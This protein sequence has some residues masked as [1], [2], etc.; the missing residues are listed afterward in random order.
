M[1][2]E[3]SGHTE[4]ERQEIKAAVIVDAGA[5]QKASK[6]LSA[7]EEMLLAK[8][9]IPE[10]GEGSY[11]NQ[12]INNDWRIVKHDKRASVKKIKEECERKKEEKRC[13]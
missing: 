5:K 9:D 4:Q 13:K 11:N 3:D 12:S 2:G 10:Q 8:V 1:G 6:D 7:A